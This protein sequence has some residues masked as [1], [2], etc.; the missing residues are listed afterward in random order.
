M[1]AFPAGIFGNADVRARVW[2]AP[3]GSALQLLSPD[4]RIAAVGYA[5]VAA[6]V[7]DGA[8]TSNKI[9]SGS[10]GTNALD[11]AQLDQRY[12]LAG[13]DRAGAA[14]LAD[15]NT[16]FISCSAPA[17]GDGSMSRPWNT[18]YALTNNAGGRLNGKTVLV[19]A[20]KYTTGPDIVFNASYT[21][22]T[23]K[24]LDPQNVQIV[25]TNNSARI[26]HLQR[27]RGRYSG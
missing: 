16:F 6:N 18:L 20:G 22:L 3:Q 8:I 2:F 14:G 9:A 4:Q 25:S 11:L 21:N 19:L 12:A 13:S 27:R 23:I 7:T 1:A 10:V 24:G 17:G 15:S 26:F 5:F